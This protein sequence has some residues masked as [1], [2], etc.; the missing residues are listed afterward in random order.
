MVDDTG[1]QQGGGAIC[2]EV[3]VSDEV[4]KEF[5][6]SIRIENP[7]SPNQGAPLYNDLV[8]VSVAPSTTCCCC[9]C[10]LNAKICSCFVPF[11]L[12]STTRRGTWGV[13]AFRDSLRRRQYVTCENVKFTATLLVCRMRAGS[14]Y[15]R[16][17]SEGSVD[18]C[19]V[20]IAGE[21][22]GSRRSRCWICKS[23][24]TSD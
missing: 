22:A 5:G 1:S 8:E 20:D 2:A 17:T 24:P 4:E 11:T 23:C 10:E 19:R 15:R 9:L 7:L 21:H 12:S 18:V 3:A 14:L 13:E 6:Y 16:D